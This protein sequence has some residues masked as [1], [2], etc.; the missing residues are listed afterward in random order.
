MSEPLVLCETTLSDAG[1]YYQ[2]EDIAE[3]DRVAGLRR[4]AIDEA[5]SNGW[6]ARASTTAN[7][8]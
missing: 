2:A 7:S 5:A 8:A 3:C 6:A 4:H 1:P